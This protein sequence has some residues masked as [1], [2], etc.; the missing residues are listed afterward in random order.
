MAWLSNRQWHT[1]NWQAPGISEALWSLSCLG[2]P[3]SA[4]VVTRQLNVH[5]IN[6]SSVFISVLYSG[7]GLW[8]M[9]ICLP[10]DRLPQC[11]L[12]S[13]HC[14]VLWFLRYNPSLCCHIP[15]KWSMRDQAGRLMY[16]SQ[17]E[18]WERTSSISLH[19]PCGDSTAQNTCLSP[20]ALVAPILPLVH[21]GPGAQMGPCGWD[22]LP[23]GHM[24]A[25]LT[26]LTHHETHHLLV[27]HCPVTGFDQM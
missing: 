26:G 12:S 14:P 8:W 16:V 20:C 24:A 25:W 10:L 15:L 7:Y 6:L 3:N 17:P 5:R 9:A 13:K 23:R 11:S 22:I 18:L 1:V 27:H 21:L 4:S 19:L 2:I